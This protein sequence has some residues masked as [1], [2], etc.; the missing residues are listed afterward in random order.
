MP[1]SLRA[2]T[3]ACPWA[4]AVTDLGKDLENRSFVIPPSLV[5]A[6]IAIHAGKT[7]R[8][9]SSRQWDPINE[10]LAG[11]IER[12]LLP[13]DKR[14]HLRDSLIKQG[15]SIV[16]L[17]TLAP[18]VRESDSPWFKGRYGWPL[19]DKFVLPK[20]IPCRGNQGL[21]TVPEEIAKQVL[22]QEAAGG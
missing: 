5:G 17:V 14:G 3:L 4:F 18:Y 15:S 2:L 8:K 20:P 9:Y 1:S 22:E 6:R 13:E 16:C 7:P 19:L 12:G 11:M 21:W 10:A